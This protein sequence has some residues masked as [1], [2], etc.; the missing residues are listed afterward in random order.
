M[1]TRLDSFIEYCEEF[2]APNGIYGHFFENNL[3]SL[4]L[5]RACEIVFR[6]TGKEFCGDSF[7]RE[8][9]RDLLLFKAGKL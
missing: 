3:A 1:K 5:I 4:D 6:L 9:V 2:Y 7:D 8:R